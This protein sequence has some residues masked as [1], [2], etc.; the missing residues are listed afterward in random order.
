MGDPYIEIFETKSYDTKD[1]TK[2]R[3]KRVMFWNQV[4]PKIAQ[5]RNIVSNN[6]PKEFQNSPGKEISFLINTNILFIDLVD[7]AAGFRHA[8]YTLVGL[9]VALMAL[10]VIC[11]I[12]LKKRSK[13][14]ERHIHLGY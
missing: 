2:N 6:I 13:D 3:N 14:R 5:R 10:L 7:P 4:L 8:M 12:L 9:V 11:I 1:E